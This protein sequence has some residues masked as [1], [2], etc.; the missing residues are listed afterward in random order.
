MYPAYCY[1]RWPK[2]IIGQYNTN[3]VYRV[4][5]LLKYDDSCVMQLCWV[6]LP[7]A[8]LFIDLNILGRF[9]FRETFFTELVKIGK[10]P[11]EK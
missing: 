1:E 2:S 11:T 10:R 3:Y 6:V 8:L 9:L 5:C 7:V 4:P